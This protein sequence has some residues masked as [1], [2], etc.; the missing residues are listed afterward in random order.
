MD[1]GFSIASQFEKLAPK[2]S[3]YCLYQQHQ[4]EHTGEPYRDNRRWRRR[5]ILPDFMPFDKGVG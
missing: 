2:P 1:K 4:N 3:R 5:D